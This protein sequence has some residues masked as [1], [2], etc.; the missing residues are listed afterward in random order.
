MVL[1]L[2]T[3]NLLTLP[4]TT[5]SVFPAGGKTFIPLLDSALFLVPKISEILDRLFATEPPAVPRAALTLT[6][7]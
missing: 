7:F 6:V 4:I 5:F 3:A 2:I 1:Y